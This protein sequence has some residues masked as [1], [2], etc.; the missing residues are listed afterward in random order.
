MRPIR[1]EFSR[2][3]HLP[4]IN[5]LS[6]YFVC[7]RVSVLCS[8][9]TAC[10]VEQ[11][12][13]DAT[14][15]VFQSLNQFGWKIVQQEGKIE[16]SRN[17]EN[18]LVTDL[19]KFVVLN[20]NISSQCFLGFDEQLP[21]RVYLSFHNNSISREGQQKNKFFGCHR[22]CAITFG[23]IIWSWQQTRAHVNLISKWQNL[24]LDLEKW[25]WFVV[26][27]CKLISLRADIWK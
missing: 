11:S 18:L 2:K 3:V 15:L 17:R 4:A 25:L 19:H 5:L 8:W 14:I 13:L 10:S 20:G 9:K 22:P 26:C 27:A 7:T 21:A 12:A 1:R 23:A 6:N 24:N 16:C